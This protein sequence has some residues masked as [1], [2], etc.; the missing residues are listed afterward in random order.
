ML[1]LFTVA[2]VLAT[3]FASTFLILNAAGVLTVENVKA[4]LVWASEVN[5]IY[6]GMF[7]VTLLFMDMFI[8]VPTLTIVTLSGYFMG[9]VFG[10]LFSVTG[11][12]LAGVSGYLICR[13]WGDGLL[14]K[15]Y[16][17]EEKL[18]EM[19][20]IFS[21]H[22]IYVLLLCRAAPILPEV[23]C[24]LSGANKIPFK[25]FF[26]F[27]S[28]GTVPYVMLATYAGSKSTIDDPMPG[29]IGAVLISVSLWIL[30]YVFI[31][32]NYRTKALPAE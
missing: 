22:G 13:K 8:A 4:W 27:Y 17:D 3:A 19:R 7:V 24:C 28:L 29:I 32:F 1:R 30:W 6:V 18:K 31:R 11:M 14:L 15:I 26:T 12:W 23:S 5:V 20:D 9:P 25:K 16:K 2:M 21:Q 10:T